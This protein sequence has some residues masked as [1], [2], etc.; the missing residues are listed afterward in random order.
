MSCPPA[1]KHQ[2]GDL[3]FHSQLHLSW[4][5]FTEEYKGILATKAASVWKLKQKS[6]KDEDED[7]P[8]KLSVIR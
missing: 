3:P 1:T 7:F 2:Q 4:V 6:V 5:C 8:G